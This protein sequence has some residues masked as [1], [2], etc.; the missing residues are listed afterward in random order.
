M[1]TPERGYAADPHGEWPN[2]LDR[3]ITSITTRSDEEPHGRESDL[4]LAGSTKVVLNGVLSYADRPGPS[5]H[6]LDMELGEGYNR[7]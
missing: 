3:S 1:S 5:P 2:F 7:V 6:S 4:N